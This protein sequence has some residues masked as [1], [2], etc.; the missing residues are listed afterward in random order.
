MN[1]TSTLPVALRNKLIDVENK[2]GIN[3]YLP[4]WVKGKIIIE[5]K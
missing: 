1:I 3:F 2:T 4:D 5:N